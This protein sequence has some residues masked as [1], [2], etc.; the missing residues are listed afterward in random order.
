M[1]NRCAPAK[2]VARPHQVNSEGYEGY[3]ARHFGTFLPRK[4][5]ANPSEV[6][7]HFFDIF[8]ALDSAVIDTVMGHV[9]VHIDCHLITCD[10]SL[11]VS[12]C[13]QTL[14][15]DVCQSALRSWTFFLYKK[16]ATSEKQKT[17]SKSL[18]G[19]TVPRDFFWFR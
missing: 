17:A 2:Y 4:G 16:H 10:A 3:A 15:A 5:P 18:L 19:R 13:E 9:N 7:V 1:G 12:T 11:C 6:G 8:A 14:A